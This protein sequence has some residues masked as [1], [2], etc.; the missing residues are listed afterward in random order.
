MMEAAQSAQLLDTQIDTILQ[1]R[2]AWH[3]L[4][5]VAQGHPET[6]RCRADHYLLPHGTIK[7]RKNS[8]SQS[9]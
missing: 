3:K 5:N 1:I 8:F 4:D 9:G 7:S 2:S 6:A